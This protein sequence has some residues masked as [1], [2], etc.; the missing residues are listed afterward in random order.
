LDG[1]ERLSGEMIHTTPADEADNALGRRVVLD[2]SHG[3]IHVSPR[4]RD[5]LLAA[6]AFQPGTP[7]VI[8]TYDEHLPT[9]WRP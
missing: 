7:L 4:G 9:G 2:S 1:G 5:K 3:C 6:G 8:H